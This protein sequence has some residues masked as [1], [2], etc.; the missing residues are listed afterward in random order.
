MFIRVWK[1]FPSRRVLK[2]LEG[3]PKRENPKR[4][5]SVSSGH[6]L[7]QMVSEQD[8]ERCASE[9]TKPRRGVDTRQCA[10]KDVGPRRGW[11]GWVSHRLEKGT[12]A[13]K[14]TGPRR[15]VD[16]EI[17]HRLGRRMKHSLQGCENLSLTSAF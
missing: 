2:N 4:T 12:S 5:I 15:G 17:P 7:L 1:P 11:I 9:E 13:S 6:G 3:T 8:T 10:S 16:C 14:D